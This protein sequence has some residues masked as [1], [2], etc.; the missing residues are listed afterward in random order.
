LEN[1]ELQLVKVESFQIF[2][3][4]E[5]FPED[6]FFYCDFYDTQNESVS[7][8]GILKNRKLIVDA[9][10]SL[11]EELQKKNEE[12]KKEEINED[13][14]EEEVIKETIEEEEDP[15][16]FK[17][18]LEDENQELVVSSPVGNYEEEH[19]EVV[20]PNADEMDTPQAVIHIEMEENR[21]AFSQENHSFKSD[22]GISLDEPEVKPEQRR[23][24]KKFVDLND[25][26]EEEKKPK[27]KKLKT[28]EDDE[29]E[30]VDL[31]IDVS[32][33]EEMPNHS[34]TK[35]KSKGKK[36]KDYFSLSEEDTQDP[37]EK[38][39]KNDT[40]SP[41]KRKIISDNEEDMKAKEEKQDLARAKKAFNIKDEDEAF[42]DKS[43]LSP[44]END[45]IS[46][47]QSPRLSYSSRKK[48]AVEKKHQLLKEIQNK[49]STTP[50]RSPPNLQE[51]KTQQK[52]EIGSSHDP[53][54][55]DDETPSATQ[56][57]DDDDNSTKP[58]RETR[59]DLFGVARRQ[60]KLTDMAILSEGSVLFLKNPKDDF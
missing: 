2:R 11:F 41:K 49:I 8:S 39:S 46:T 51:S 21:S 53:I 25:T 4:R 48:E 7:S 36:L 43:Y 14:K 30:K 38:K 10:I 27:K 20:I 15:P 59:R 29:K 52:K 23:R 44:D 50:K 31:Q 57:S 58:K 9:R 26:D 32:E 42:L 3:E 12:T 6:V 18:L 54:N 16:S 22:S 1:V 17:I 24:L 28:D 5:N 19:E 55:L 33:E 45:I 35:H 40:I 47:T 13:T 37:E 56:H 60:Q 34:N